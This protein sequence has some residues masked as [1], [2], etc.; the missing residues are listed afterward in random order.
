MYL[1]CDNPELFNKPLLF[2]PVLLPPQKIIS[3]FFE[4]YSLAEIREILWKWFDAAITSDNDQYA[5]ASARADLLL[6]YQKLELLVEAVYI[7]RQTVN[8]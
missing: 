8:K 4:D 1:Y 3:N 6:A 2:D 7:L 5:E